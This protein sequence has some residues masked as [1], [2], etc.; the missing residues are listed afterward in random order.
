MTR[1]QHRMFTREPQVLSAE[2]NPNQSLTLNPTANAH[3]VLTFTYAGTDKPIA[4]IK[5]TMTEAD[6]TVT[7]LATDSNGQVTLP[8][9]TNTYTLA[10][11]LTETGS[12]PVDLLDAIWILQHDVSVAAT[13]ASTALPQLRRSAAT[14]TATIVLLLL[15]LLL[16]QAA[17][18]PNCHYCAAATT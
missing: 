8:T 14:A 12:D 1:Q 11:S 4:G 3:T 16:Q 10:A 15:P 2:L 5:I 6:G 7:V 13:T 18:Y 9:T 17:S